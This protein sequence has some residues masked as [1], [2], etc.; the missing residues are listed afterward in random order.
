MSGAFY[1][2]ICVKIETNTQYDSIKPVLEILKKTSIDFDI[3]I[4]RHE[5][6]HNGIN[7]MYDN[8][9]RLIK[10]DGFENII[11]KVAESNVYKI[12]LIAPHYDASIRAKFHIKYSYGA[13][14]STKPSITHRAEML[15]HYHAQL[16]CSTRDIEIFSAF[17]KTYLVPDLKY[18]GYTHKTGGEKTKTILIAP[19]W[20]D[21]NSIDWIMELSNRLKGYRIIVK[22]HP[23]GNFGT[24]VDESTDAIKDKIKN[25]VDEYYEEDG[26]LSEIISRCD[27]VISNTSGAVF[28][29]LYVGIPVIMYLT[30]MHRFNEGSLLSANVKYANEGYI[31]SVDNVDG[32]IREIPISLKKPYIRRQKELSEKLFEQDFSIDAGEKWMSVIRKYLND[33]IDDEYTAMQNIFTRDFWHY[34]NKA[35][36]MTQEVINRDETIACLRSEVTSYHGVKR[37]ARLLLGNIKRKIKK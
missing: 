27:I 11:R 25:S 6:N 32:L 20:E 3:Y 12:A 7:H 22:L 24:K 28:D 31:T 17:C 5:D 10:S 9:N 4:P 8:T 37:S 2:Q 13:I 26:V 14:L 15:N 23:F 1:K 33:E 18:A 36:Q 19:S 29:A 21:Q 35:D 34:K 16:L 30:D